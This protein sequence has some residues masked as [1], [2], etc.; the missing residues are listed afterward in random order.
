MQFILQ[1]VVA[2]KGGGELP[3]Y[4]D[5]EDEDCEGVLVDDSEV[6]EWI[7]STPTPSTPPTNYY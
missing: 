7:L 2:L 1:Q 3:D 5:D 4:E 6:E